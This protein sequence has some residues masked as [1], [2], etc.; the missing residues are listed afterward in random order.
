MQNADRSV[1]IKLAQTDYFLLSFT[2]AG[3]HPRTISLTS[4]IIG[5]F[6]KVQFSWL[7][8]TKRTVYIVDDFLNEVSNQRHILYHEEQ[9]SHL[10][11]LYYFDSTIQRPKCISLTQCITSLHYSWHDKSK[12]CSTGSIFFPMI[13]FNNFIFYVVFYV[14]IFW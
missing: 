6:R 1:I 2:Y 10:L 5:F 4:S 7:F 8:W 14:N 3:P 13:Y 11:P 9:F 12:Q